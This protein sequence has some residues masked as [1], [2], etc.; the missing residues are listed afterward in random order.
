MLI[1]SGEEY[2]KFYFPFYYYSRTTKSQNKIFIVILMNRA[3]LLFG[4][5]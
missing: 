3:K 1:N 2:K 5:H 4:C